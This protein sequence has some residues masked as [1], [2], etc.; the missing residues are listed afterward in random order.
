MN[1]REHW[2]SIIIAELDWWTHSR[3]NEYGH[4]RVGAVNVICSKLQ[5][6][7]ALHSVSDQRKT[8]TKLHGKPYSMEFSN[9]IAFTVHVIEPFQKLGQ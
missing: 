1:T 4:T 6:E 5:N 7:D 3:I 8:A 9:A 2:S